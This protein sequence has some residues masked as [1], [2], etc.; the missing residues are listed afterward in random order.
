MNTITQKLRRGTIEESL[1]ARMKKLAK[2]K[3]ER[4][5]SDPD[6]AANAYAGEMEQ[7]TLMAEAQR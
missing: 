1:A 3:L 5:I 2:D 6:Y 7:E 4:A